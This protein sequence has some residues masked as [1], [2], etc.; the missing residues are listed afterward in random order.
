MSEILT[1]DYQL[2][3]LPSSQHRA[4]LAG[5][6]LVRR[7]LDRQPDDS[8]FK[9]GI[10]QGAVCELI[11]TEVQRASLRLDKEGLALLFNEIYAANEEERGSPKRRKDVQPL[12]E[13]DRETT[14]KKGNKRYK[15][16]YIYPVLVPKGSF[17]SDP[18]YDESNEGLWI[19]LWRDVMFQIL[20]G[21]GQAQTPFKERA[22]DPS[23][24]RDTNE[25][26]KE[27]TGAHTG[28]GAELSSSYFLG[29]QKHN[30]EKVKFADRAKFKFLLNFWSFAVQIYIPPKTH[31]KD[32]DPGYALAIPDISNLKQFCKRFPDVLKKR[33]PKSRGYRPR[34]CFV[35]IPIESA[36]NLM[37]RLRGPLSQKVGEDKTASSI[38]A[39]D[40]IH[41]KKEGNNINLLGMER[42]KP[43]RVMV[44]EYIKIRD[45]F[46]DTRFRRQCLLNLISESPWY[47]GFDVLFCCRPY[48][49][50]LG[51]GDFDPFCR[52]V[53]E[54]FNSLIEEEKQMNDS[55][56]SHSSKSEHSV[57]I[58]IFRLVKTYVNQKLQEKYQLDWNQ[59]W[60]NLSKEE[61]EKLSS[62][63]DYQEYK[64]K[65]GKIAK[66]AF[67][68]V[69]SRTERMEFINYFAA[70]L[71]SVP[72]HMKP[73]DYQRLTQAL[74]KEPEKVR[75][76]T[77]LALSANS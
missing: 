77:L 49:K 53:R 31:D 51:S 44:D 60:N 70:S 3:E 56:S 66:S 55:S 62:R 43:N 11:R 73:E 64:D 75:T 2:A 13:E 42:I 17:L 21:S 12:R 7:W 33:S 50:T 69:R 71:C 9:Q 6:V 36:L 41:A 59:E 37:A 24:C 74:F 65:K 52:D 18:S 22:K 61:K 10:Q 46:R 47:T 4:G 15:K 67:L 25:T 54:K 57:E 1:L 38:L 16:V 19:K 23:Y 72:Q 28:K 76:L 32:K 68:D 5:L 20:R 14:D 34:D 29:A 45:I 35:D 58:L 63:K 8:P 39:I 48:D 26:W 40:V 30:P 27:L